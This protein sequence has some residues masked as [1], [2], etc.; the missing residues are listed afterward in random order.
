MLILKIS[1]VANSA[2]RKHFGTTE[3]KAKWVTFR[4]QPLLKSISINYFLQMALRQQPKFSR[5]IIYHLGQKV[6]EWYYWWQFQMT[7]YYNQYLLH[8]I[9][10][11]TMVFLV[12]PKLLHFLTWFPTR[13]LAHFFTQKKLHFLH[14]T[15]THSVGSG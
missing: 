3:N 5:L 15:I 4:F 12:I 1:S 10:G 9:Y 6:W 11:V 14:R 7:L 2:M 8:I 13:V